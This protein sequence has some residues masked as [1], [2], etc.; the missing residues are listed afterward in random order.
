MRIGRPGR[1]THGTPSPGHGWDSGRPKLF[2]R[3]TPSSSRGGP[4]PGPPE[5]GVGLLTGDLSRP[6]NHASRLLHQPPPSATLGTHMPITMNRAN[7]ANR[8][9]QGMSRPSS[10][11][12]VHTRYHLSNSPMSPRVPYEEN[13]HTGSIHYESDD[14]MEV[15]SYGNP[16][17]ASSL[18]S[19]DYG[20]PQASS[21]H[22][23]QGYLPYSPH[24]YNPRDPGY[25]AQSPAHSQPSSRR[26]SRS[27]SR[28]TTPAQYANAP[29]HRTQQQHR[30]RS[31]SRHVSRSPPPHHH[32]SHR[33][34]P[35]YDGYPDG[36]HPLYPPDQHHPSS[37]SSSRAHPRPPPRPTPQKPPK[38]PEQIHP[39]SRPFC[40][41][42]ILRASSGSSIDSKTKAWIDPILA[43]A[44]SLGI[45]M[46]CMDLCK[47]VDVGNEKQ[48]REEYALFLFLFLFFLFFL[49]F[50]L[51]FFLV[52]G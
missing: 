41:P 11:S 32:R 37:S 19:R 50:F 45:I 12:P 7:R 1:D 5:D 3:S 33:P 29:R 6:I 25:Y 16:S 43:D 24:G 36:Q 28:F 35:Q 31:R 34:S 47:L 40:A 22:D 44:Y 23:S 2:D 26:A 30:S 18:A 9:G 21:R 27:P 13:G 46:V 14:W 20:Y 15:D 52:F 8:D 48:K 4:P 10:T 39:G 17:S 51:S 42:E 49:S 38:K